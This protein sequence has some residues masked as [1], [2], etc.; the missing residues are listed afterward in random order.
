MPPEGAVAAGIQRTGTVTS[1]NQ[2][3]IEDRCDGGMEMEV[4]CIL[5]A[6]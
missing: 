2:R 6:R 3:A 5:R 1:R 4:E